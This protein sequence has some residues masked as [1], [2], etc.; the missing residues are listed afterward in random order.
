M[1]LQHAIQFFSSSGWFRSRR[2]FNDDDDD[3]DDCGGAVI[4]ALLLHAAGGTFP[5]TRNTIYSNGTPTAKEC[6]LSSASF[7]K[8]ME[9]L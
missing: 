1:Q 3:N 6:S 2:V 7:S 9:A 8:V 4:V 5:D